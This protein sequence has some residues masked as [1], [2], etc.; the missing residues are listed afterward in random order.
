MKSDPNETTVC[1]VDFLQSGKFFL[2]LAKVDLKRKYIFI[3]HL[4][5]VWFACLR[6]GVTCKLISNF[7][8]SRDYIDLNL[9]ETRE[10]QCG[11]LNIAKADSMAARYLYTLQQLHQEFIIRNLLIW[12]GQTIV[13]K[14]AKHCN[15]V[16]GLKTLFFEISNVPGKIVVDPNG[17]N[18]ESK[19]YANLQKGLKLP[20]CNNIADYLS[21]KRE[22]IGSK[23]HNNIV[24][25][26]I[27]KNRLNFYLVCDYVYA[28][29]I[30]Y[31]HYSKRS[32]DNK[33][34]IKKFI[35][36]FSTKKPKIKFIND[37]GNITNF[38]FY[39]GQ[40]HDDTQLLLNSKIGNIQAIKRILKTTSLCVFVKPHPAGSA[41]EYEEFNDPIFAGRVIFTNANTFELIMKANEV[42]TIN[43]T[44]G[45]EALIIGKKVTFFGKSLYKE[46]K[47]S[48][49][50][51]FI[52]NYLIDVDFFSDEKG[53]TFDD[54]KAIYARTI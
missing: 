41:D 36:K 17:V 37:L 8:G 9:D 32:F 34:P 43:S 30:G 7:F 18:S 6:E 5:S 46:I 3:T 49:L 53:I 10:L 26:A 16:F 52:K 40:V 50:P 45:L 39:P 1:L 4:P 38:D 2:R 29:T 35:Q 23:S 12:N 14:I 54:V 24:P 13:G 48:D 11:I 44:V 42:Y 19:L 25:Q 31:Q 47:P 28:L 51:W 27:N 33:N 15:E 22:Y 21:W 20:P